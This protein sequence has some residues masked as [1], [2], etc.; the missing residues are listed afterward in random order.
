MY[1]L[2]SL[3]SVGFLIT[4]IAFLKTGIAKNNPP[5]LLNFQASRIIVK[6]ESTV[7]NTT[8]GSLSARDDDG[9]MD[10]MF[11]IA[12]DATRNL[13]RLSDYRGESATGRTVDIIL[14]AP[15]DRD[16]E[17][18]ERKLYFELADGDSSVDHNS[19]RFI[20]ALYASTSVLVYTD[21]NDEVPEFSTLR[22]KES[23]YENATVGTT[24]TRVSANDPDN[25]LGGTVT[26]SMQTVDDGYRNAFRIDPNHG[27][28]IVNGPLDYEKHNFYEFI[29]KA[30][31]GYGEESKVNADFVLTI[32]DI[33]DTPPAFY[34]LPYSI[35]MPEDKP[36]GGSVLQ[37]TALDGDRGNPNSITYRFVSGNFENF[38]INSSTGLITVRQTLDR[39][40]PAVQLRG[41]VYAMYVGEVTTAG[42]NTSATTLVTV[43]VSD[44]NDNA[45]QFSSVQYEA[46]IP[47]HMDD[48]VPIKFIGAN[49]ILSVSDKDQ[50]SN[51]HFELTLMQNN[52][53]Y[54]DFSPLPPEGFSESSVLIRVNN[55]GNL[56]FEKMNQTTFQ[57]V[58][59]EIGT[60]ERRSSTATITV[61]IEDMND[62]QPEFDQTSYLAYIAENVSPGAN[63]TRVHATD[64]DSGI[65]GEIT[66]SLR[67]G[68]GRF[69]I[70]DKTGRVT[71]ADVLDREKVNEYYLTAEAR[72]GG[73]FRSTVEL[74]IIVTDI[75]DNTPVFVRN[76]YFSTIK[77]KSMSFLRGPLQVEATDNDDLTTNNSQVH[78]RIYSTPPGLQN[79]FS[80][81]TQTGE[82][83]LTQPLDY[84]K[85]DQSLHGVVILEVQALDLGVPPLS[86]LINVTVEVEDENDNVPLF[87]QTSYS[88]SLP[89]NTTDATVSLTVTAHDAD[90]TAPNNE[91]VYRIDSG[92]QDK[93]RINFR[94]GE[95]SVEVGAKLN[96]EEKSTYI[97]NI[98]AT[99]RGAVSLVGH[100][101]V[102]I[103]VTDVNDYVP[104]FNPESQENSIHETLSVNSPV[105]TYTATDLDLD[106][107]L[108]YSITS[109]KAEDDDG[110]DVD[111][112]TI[113]VQ[114]YFGIVPTNGT[115]YVKTPLDRETAEVIT[116]KIL[117]K[118]LNAWEPPVNLQT[119]T[120][121]LTITL[122]DDN[123]NDPKFQYSVYNVNV[124]E[125][126]D[127]LDNI[128]TV[129]A[130]DADRNQLISYSIGDDS[131]NSFEIV[132]PN[133][134]TV[135]L[136][137]RLD[138]EIEP[139]V[140]FT[141]LARDNGNPVRTS[142]ATVHVT[143]TDTNDNSPVFNPYQLT[144]SVS[145]DAPNGTEIAIIDATDKD[146]GDFAKIQYSMEISNNDD[147]FS[148][149]P[150]TG[151][152]I[153]R[154]RLDFEQTRTYSIYVKATDNPD[155]DTNQRT[156]QTQAIQINVN[157][158]NDN[159]PTIVNSGKKPKIILENA[160][161]DT[162]VETVSATDPD[163][164][165]NGTV[166]YQLVTTDTNASISWFS[167]STVYN[168][169]KGA[170]EGVI[171]LKE[172]LL[173]RVGIYY[174]TVRAIDKGTPFR[175]SS[176][177]TLLFEV[178]DVNLH[179]P[180]FVVPRGPQATIQ[181]KEEQPI[182]TQVLVVSASDEDH[183]KNAEVHYYL[184][185][186]KDY[187]KFNLD[188]NTGNLTTAEVLDREKMAEYELKIIANDSGQTNV[189]KNSITLFVRLL[190]KND[191]DPEFQV[192]MPYRI[193]S[194]QEE[195]DRAYVGRVIEP[196]DLDSD[197]NNTL[198]FYYIV[199]GDMLQHF[200]LNR[201]N[202]D[203]YL[204]KSIDRENG[205]GAPINFVN[206]VIWASPI[207][208]LSDTP[209]QRRKRSLDS[210]IIQ[211][212][213]RSTPP[214]IPPADYDPTNKT[215]L[216]AQVVIQDVNDHPPEFRYKNLSIGI[217]RKTQFGEIIFNLKE[218]VTDPDIGNN[219]VHSYVLSS[220]TSDP[221]TL[222]SSVGAEP[223]KL[224]P[225]GTIKTNTYF[226]SDIYGY[227]IMIVKVKDTHGNSDTAEVKISLINDDQ[228][229]KVI[230]RMTPEQVRNFSTEFKTRLERITG[231][232]IVVDKIQTHEN[233]QGKPEVDK[234]DMFIHGER[235]NPFAIVD[236]AELLSKID[237]KATELIPVLNDYNIL[238]IVPTTSQALEED[239]SRTLI[240]AI[241][242]LAI[243][244]GIPCIVM[245]IV[246][247]LIR[248]KYQ[249]KLKAATAM[250][251][252][253]DS[254]LQKL[255]LPGT[256]IHAY[257]NANPIFLEK[258]LL[259]ES[260]EIG[261]D[262]SIDNNEVDA[263]QITPYDVQEASMHFPRETD[264][265]N[266][267]GPPDMNLKAALSAHDSVN[268]RNGTSS[269]R[270]P[271]SKSNGHIDQNGGPNS[272]L[273]HGLQTTDI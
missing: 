214:N 110:N 78:Y 182:G 95:I 28:I 86:S 231:Y 32:M 73:G 174:V 66:Y 270:S 115:I 148:I 21:V 39:D 216:W 40:D 221:D 256:N 125:G 266:I 19:V 257:E 238:Q 207:N 188:P 246:I 16:R 234:T 181:I 191:H 162:V 150:D 88:A 210:D 59:R 247:F 232:K 132:N 25:G 197:A 51:S 20:C 175:L 227:F 267:L 121:I 65:R 268:K 18:P 154:K 61:F 22:Y 99:D 253:Q 189:L 178:V 17:P 184:S 116:L 211:R 72:D 229:V 199:G 138:R 30:K 263:S 166:E 183:G 195:A 24:I 143:V 49:T 144:Y 134:G 77:E 173:S 161:I 236:A 31:D 213:K 108:Q 250:A 3:P 80:I 79:N 142:T 124:S 205:G 226:K 225:N 118:D 83:T 139:Q 57:I 176:N 149:D 98:S 104:V 46:T 185:P 33:Q 90:G 159:P 15:L 119:A 206:L 76:E 91:F 130:T 85:L 23:V 153:V 193:G 9:P 38:G 2:P 228:R 50:G 222:L 163:N 141:I 259:E 196:V 87:E 52:Q 37:V 89:E 167:I 71:V 35:V 74:H 1:P 68:N 100:C 244:L 172:N 102:T 112:T 63:V 123:D 169:D 248:Q 156:T 208:R 203:L 273:F 272:R 5:E 64:L 271:G 10:V 58:A 160:Q 14:I 239:S 164:G 215:L 158:V 235:E 233:D 209:S 6:P 36:V 11:S 113:G 93:F 190:D 75:N 252:G 34:N 82:I 114:D 43:T 180:Q 243:L 147:C 105:L 117:V 179:Q 127:I 260:G 4:A 44:I 264:K 62:N 94:T 26:Y 45:P 67:G 245:I 81:N 128:L 157:D 48:G 126:R 230:F 237:S 122:L 220:F 251:Y 53:P 27:D 13:V 186:E 96:R 133:S 177:R 262:D 84:E 152:V 129:M 202:G 155:D 29:I 212:S 258:V 249:R 60:S 56:D 12:D 145:E 101:V 168:P 204:I 135:R 109:V 241:I 151:R 47:E 187:Q 69:A 192:Q 223:F 224:F 219:S 106:K 136:R 140:T 240:M 265:D 70:N 107:N 165:D 7:V 54:Y 171:I 255:Q 146:E 194:V 137:R 201:T 103:N 131:T 42:G 254:D 111:V 200:E 218:D 242:L 97:L 55:S 92:A 8:I 217:T 120:A 269:F 261:D 170:N 41:G 198:V